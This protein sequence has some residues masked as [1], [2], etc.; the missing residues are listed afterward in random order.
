MPCIER[1]V[2]YN[3]SIE[4]EI[5]QTWGGGII[6]EWLE[7]DSI[8]TFYNGTSP[9]GFTGLPNGINWSMTVPSGNPNNRLLG[10]ERGCINFSGITNDNIGD[11]RLGIY[12]CLK[13][14]LSPSPLCDEFCALTQ[15]IEGLGQSFFLEP[16]YYL[17]VKNS[18]SA[19]DSVLNPIICSTF[20]PLDSINSINVVANNNSICIGDTVDL[21][22]FHQGGIAPYTYTWSNGAGNLNAISVSPSTTTTYSVTITDANGNTASN[23]VTINVSTQ[24]TNVIAGKVRLSTNDSIANMKVLLI[25]VDSSFNVNAVDSTLTD[26][27][28]NFTFT[29]TGNYLYVKAIPDSTLYPNEMPT[30]HYGF[31]E[32]FPF[33]LLFDLGLSSP[34]CG[35]DNLFFNTL[36]G[37]NPG[38]SGFISGNIF[39]GAG[40]RQNAAAVGQYVFLVNSNNEPVDYTVTNADG[41]FAFSNIALTNYRIFVDVPNF[42]VNAAPNVSLNNNTP[43]AENLQFYLEDLV[44]SVILKSFTQIN[45]VQLFPNPSKGKVTITTEFNGLVK[46][47]NLSITDMQGKEIFAEPINVSGKSF[48]KTIDLSNSPKGLYFIQLKANEVVLNRKLMVY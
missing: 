46:Q 1:G 47:I 15:T 31:T 23:S 6:V 44:N 35:N 42:N 8:Q 5:P 36:S 29:A 4:F 13:I 33:L 3:Q 48:E 20:Q 19:C 41:Y 25:Q 28:G 38:G 11:Y 34:N 2:A 40:K 17:R 7:I 32:A 26:A 22:V 9:V 12:V 43:T 24:P 39:Q 18:G 21:F 37:N 10:G 16:S 45:D 27:S 14:N 30:Y